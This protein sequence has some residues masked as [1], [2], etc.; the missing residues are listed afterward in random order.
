M[1]KAFLVVLLLFSTTAYCEPDKVVFH[2]NQ[3]E[4]GVFLV[5]SV[6][7]YLSTNPDSEVV[8]V[9]N[10]SGVMRL[11]RH[12]DL[13]PAVTSFINKGVEVGACNNAIISNSLDTEKLIS[14]VKVLTEGGISRLV[15]LQK[16]GYV[17]IKI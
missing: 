13:S 2:L 10:N 14:G 17:Y 6:R 11:M 12:G 5:N 9:V 8:I 7:N 4:K 1:K 3:K 15:E 16:Q